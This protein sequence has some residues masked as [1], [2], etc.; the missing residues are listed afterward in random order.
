MKKFL[1]FTLIGIFVV[2][3][4]MGILGIAGQ[5]IFANWIRHNDEEITL[6]FNWQHDGLVSN[7][8]AP[9]WRNDDGEITTRP[10]RHNAPLGTDVTKPGHTFRYW[11]DG[12]GQLD[13][14]ESGERLP[15]FSASDDG[16]NFFAVWDAN[17]YTIRFNTGVA[18]MHRAEAELEFGQ[19]F[20]A[21]ML[22]PLPNRDG[23]NFVHWYVQVNGQQVPV[24]PGD[25][26]N[27]DHV[28]ASSSVVNLRAHWNPTAPAFRNFR[29][30]FDTAGGTLNIG[31][32]T[33]DVT[34]ANVD[35]AL[36]G[37][38][39]ANHTS[40]GWFIH[41]TRVFTPR[42]A[43]AFL[44]NLNTI[45]VTHRW[46]PNVQQPQ[47]QTLT[48]TFNPNGGT[49]NGSTATFTRQ[50]QSGT[51]VANPG[52]PTRTGYT[53]VVWATNQTGTPITQ[54]DFSLPRTAGSTLTFHARWNPV[55]GGG[56]QQPQ[57]QTLTATFN[58]NGGTF[59][60]STATFTRQF[61]SGTAIA[62]PGNPTRANHTFRGWFTIQNGNEVMVDFSL[63][64]TANSSL[65]FHALWTQTSGGGQQQ[66]QQQIV[67]RVIFN[68]NG[69][70][71]GHHSSIHA[72]VRGRNNVSWGRVVGA[73]TPF[74]G[75]FLSAVRQGGNYV[76]NTSMISRAGQ[77]RVAWGYRANS[78]NLSAMV[79]STVS[80]LFRNGNF[81]PTERVVGNTIERT[82]TVFA[83][84]R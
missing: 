63:A 8:Y 40:G 74:T 10:D 42:D 14:I 26:L 28:T 56:Q 21:A 66:P 62:N 58:P 6:V 82:I 38:T 18:H 84:W 64:R 67:Y 17:T 59:N 35:S 55:S 61:Q 41:A 39:R 70:T 46:T 54:V 50:F 24:I 23:W 1:L 71:W 34:A 44:G 52:S 75:D 43:M 29:I 48:A 57:P 9:L 53:F 30:N 73:N 80:Q 72:D 32:S 27:S 16:R 12:Q 5:G 78:F 76:N 45:T 49:F 2:F 22:A 69:G 25:S 31:G 11:I 20:T 47:P 13:P 4:V 83:I 7:V 15:A 19:P 79:G 68:P 3:G 51:A 81:T 65:A 36:P 37:A 60:G 33:L 77:S